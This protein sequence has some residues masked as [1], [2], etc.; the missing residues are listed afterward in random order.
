MQRPEHEVTTARSPLPGGSDQEQMRAERRPEQSPRNFHHSWQPAAWGLPE[1]EL[2]SASSCLV[3]LN[4]PFFHE[5]SNHFQ[6]YIYFWHTKHP[7]A[8]IP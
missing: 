8:W 1:L 2:T 6:A 4:G 5:L 7:V 3:A